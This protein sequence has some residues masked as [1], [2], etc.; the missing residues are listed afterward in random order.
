MVET[1]KRIELCNQAKFYKNRLN[2]G[3][4]MV[5]VRFF[6]MAAA[7]MLDFRNLKFLT[8]KLRHCAK[9]RRNRSN[10]GRDMRVLILCEFGIKCQFTPIWGR[11][12][13]HFPRMMSLIDL[14][15]KGPSLG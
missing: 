8:V 5:I 3:R 9:L 14:P 1:V 13:A 11:F 10:R 7:A 2:C 4:D 6:K 12:G 15:Q